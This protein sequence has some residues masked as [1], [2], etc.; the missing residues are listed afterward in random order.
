MRVEHAIT[1]SVVALGGKIP[2]DPRPVCPKVE[3]VS[4]V[5]QLDMHR[6]NRIPTFGEIPDRQRSVLRLAFAE[7]RTM[8][9]HAFAWYPLSNGHLH[10]SARGIYRIPKPPTSFIQRLSRTCKILNVSEFG[11]PLR[12]ENDADFVPR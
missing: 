11:L 5:G 9:D 12:L 6:L 3:S 2:R 4:S 1:S 10:S 8:T 7:D